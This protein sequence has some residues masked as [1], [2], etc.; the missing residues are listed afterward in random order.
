MNLLS[1]TSSYFK[2]KL[3][4]QV[5]K[6]QNIVIGIQLGSWARG[7]E[8]RSNDEVNFFIQ[9]SHLEDEELF[10]SEEVAGYSMVKLQL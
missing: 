5:Q 4:W 1:S 9:L 8:R 7:L 2:M 3:Y 6:S 10:I